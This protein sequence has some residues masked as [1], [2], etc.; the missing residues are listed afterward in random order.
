MNSLGDDHTLGDTPRVF[1]ADELP[2]MR[3]IGAPA[4]V[5]ALPSPPFWGDYIY[6]YRSVATL[7]RISSTISWPEVSIARW[8]ERETERR[9]D[10]VHEEG[11]VRW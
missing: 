3:R 9:T 8:R 2:G 6:M 10:R 5:A 1:L 4:S 11:G 7:A